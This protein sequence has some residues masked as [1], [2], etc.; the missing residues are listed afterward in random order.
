[1]ELT[2]R[3]NPTVVENMRQEWMVL[4]AVLQEIRLA[5]IR[6]PSHAQQRRIESAARALRGSLE[7][8]RT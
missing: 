8:L 3:F 1:V 6:F 7:T 2:R 4:A 5:G